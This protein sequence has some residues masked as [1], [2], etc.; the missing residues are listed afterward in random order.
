M[1]LLRLIVLIAALLFSSVSAS[2]QDQSLSASHIV[3]VA[4]KAG[5]YL[6][7][8]SETSGKFVYLFDAASNTAKDEYNVL[9]H[10]GTVYALM[11]LYGITKDER[12]RQTAE[13][14]IRYIADTSKPSLVQHSPG[15]LVVE[16]GSF[17]LGAN[18]LAGLSIVE[19]ERQTGDTSFRPLLRDLMLGITDYQRDDGSFVS[20]I[21][22]PSGKDSGFISAYYP[23]E[24]IFAL[25]R[26]YF[27]LG[28]RSYLESARRGADFLVDVRDR[29]IADDQLPHDHW[30][31]YAL[32]ELH[33]ALPE[34]KY[35]EHSKKIVGAILRAQL[36]KGVSTD[37][38]GGFD[39]PPRS[40]PAAT[41]TEGLLAAYQMLSR[42]KE[43]ALLLS[44]R[45]C[46][47]RAINF[48]LR[49]FLDEKDVLKYAAG[50][51]LVGGFVEALDESTIRIDTVQHNLSS[52]VGYLREFHPTL[53][54]RNTTK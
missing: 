20:K 10:S 5:D 40:S 4:R 11:E 9:R 8:M 37:W 44:M 16:A 45:S 42:V 1:P 47:E 28:D 43:G 48:Q 18:G 6:V 23:G 17:K 39:K 33:R 15:K 27:L 32:N 21:Y 2:S 24:A 14:A 51:K 25:M 7:R 53:D 13:K 29:G 49:T 34:K 35:V 26:S 31:L 54:L 12:L 50:R 36:V 3:A 38:I 19:Y 46:I 52:L 22:Y 30:L 41:R